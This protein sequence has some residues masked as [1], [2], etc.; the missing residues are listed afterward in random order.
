MHQIRMKATPR[1]VRDMNI[2]SP[3]FASVTLTFPFENGICL[4]LLLLLLMATLR[5]A[6]SP[7]R[8]RHLLN[9]SSCYM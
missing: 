1:Q 4:L 2:A 6:G 3:V 5:A 8:W 9:A 7:G